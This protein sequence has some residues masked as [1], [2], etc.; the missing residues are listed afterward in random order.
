MEN[1]S[2]S[3]RWETTQNIDYIDLKDLKRF[4]M[5]DLAPRKQKSTDFYTP[6]LGEK[7]H[8]LS[9]INMRDLICNVAQKMYF[10]QRK[11]LLS[12]ALKVQLGT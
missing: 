1:K 3:I 7:M 9:N 8:R 4:S 10:I 5:E 2:A 11:T 12:C 6:P